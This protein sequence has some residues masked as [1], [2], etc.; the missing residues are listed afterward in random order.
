[1]S[2]PS[3]LK[4]IISF[5]WTISCPDYCRE[6]ITEPNVFPNAGH[7]IAIPSSRFTYW[8]WYKV[9]PFI[10]FPNKDIDS[11]DG[12]LRNTFSTP[13][14][15]YRSVP[16]K[17]RQQVFRDNMLALRLIFSF[18]SLCFIAPLCPGI[19]LKPARKSHLVTSAD[20]LGS[21]HLLM[22][23]GSQGTMIAQSHQWV[24]LAEGGGGA[25]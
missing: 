13:Y 9:D 18:S 25:K 4:V 7:V 16:V 14:S 22:I 3:S 11:D 10:R 21:C 20:L 8:L 24:L 5:V 6:C 17:W 15:L 1:M 23:A 12:K 2:Y 19:R